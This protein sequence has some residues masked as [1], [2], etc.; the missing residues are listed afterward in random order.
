MAEPQ[1]PARALG[2][3]RNED[4]T[5][6]IAGA[7]EQR[8]GGDIVGREPE[9]GDESPGDT[10]TAIEPPD[11]ADALRFAVLGQRLLVR[12]AR[13]DPSNLLSGAQVTRVGA[14]EGAKGLAVAEIADGSRLAGAEL[15][16]GDRIVRVNGVDARGLLGQRAAL[17]EIASSERWLLEVEGR[18]GP[19]S[20]EIVGPDADRIRSADLTKERFV[21]DLFE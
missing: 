11:R 14:R 17:R 15:E 8:T 9:A 1:R 7:P 10:R 12:D 19:R 5:A 18:R 16:D 2:P 13:E 6:V 20:V 3:Q 4:I 21:S